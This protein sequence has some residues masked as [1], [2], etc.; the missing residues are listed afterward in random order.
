MSRIQWVT[1][2]DMRSS[3]GEFTKAPHRLGALTMTVVLITMALVASGQ[4][5]GVCTGATEEKVLVIAMSSDVQT[6]DPAKTSAM[7]GPASMIYETLITRDL[8][9]D[10]AD[11]LAEWWDLN[12]DDPDHPTFELKLREGVMFHDGLQFDTQ[13]VK[14]VIDY[15]AQNESWVQYQFWS[16]Y[17]FQNKTGWPDAGIWCKDD[18]NMVLNLTWADVSLQFALSNLYSSMMSPDALE[19]DGLALYGTPSGQVVGTGPFMLEEWVPGDH[20]T[21]VKNPDY[22]WGFSWYENKGPAKIDMIIYRII[23]DQNTRYAGFESGSIDVLQQLT[24]AKIE[25]YMSNPEMTVLTGPGQGLYY[26]EFNCLKDPWTNAS[27]RRAFGYVMDRAQI[28]EVVW[29]VVGQEGVNYLPPIL[30]ESTGVP[31][32][33]NFSLDLDTAAGL[34]LDAGY[35]DLNDDGW[36]ENVYGDLTIDL[37]TTNK[38]EDIAMGEVLAT[39]FEAFGVHV[40]LTP[41]G[42]TQLLDEAREGNH[43]AILFCYS[44][45]RA[46][47]LDWHLGTWA[48]GGS[49][50]AWYIDPV[51]DSYVTDW[52]YAETEDEYLENTT[53]G[54]IRLLTQGPWAPV[55]YWSQIFALNS[56]VT[57]WDINPFGQEVVFNAV[58]V[59]ILT[60]EAEAP[61]LSITSPA[62]GSILSVPTVVV[63]GFTDPNVT[64]AVNGLLVAVGASGE[65]ELTVALVNG[66]NLIT[67]TA[68]DDD[69]ATTVSVNVT[70]I[71]PVPDLT[72][73]ISQLEDETSQLQE[74]LEDALDDLDDAQSELEEQDETI[75]S[76]ESMRT[77]LLVAVVICVGLLAAMG[78]ALLR[79]RK[80]TGPPSS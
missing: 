57:G 27:L 65:F 68:T 16:I 50:T 66:T 55:L 32:M 20:V 35:E 36:L 53:A 12:R 46:E 60:Q 69:A 77:L 15:L 10:Y 40:T 47:I 1:D 7:Y 39:Q 21:L 73:Q 34:F 38:G 80:N 43:D 76:L 18:Y 26:V 79:V 11:G 31:S 49:N 59:D 8:N 62:E 45:P 58:D 48:V 74:D 23:A 14:R 25:E 24:P 41:Y 71:D 17:G 75:S 28:L 9:G 22:D 37:W 61:T 2:R 70:Y 51:F 30:P 64:L 78:I 13:A 29:N 54:H 6:M 5:E 19:E 52:F 44:W 33:Y 56:R 42:E 3:A 67:A 72:E 4:I 63:T